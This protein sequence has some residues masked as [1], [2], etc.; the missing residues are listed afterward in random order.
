MIRLWH[1]YVLR[2]EFEGPVEI[3]G[4]L[5]WRDHTCGRDFRSPMA[6]P[7]APPL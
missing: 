6:D 3:D 5:V 4:E 2:H 7:D 1:Q